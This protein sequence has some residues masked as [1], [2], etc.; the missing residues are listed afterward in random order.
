MLRAL[1]R[2]RRSSGPSSGR[3]RIQEVLRRF[4]VR[5]GWRR[6]SRDGPAH[7]EVAERPVLMEARVVWALIIVCH[8]RHSFVWPPALVSME[9]APSSVT[10]RQLPPPG[11]DPLQTH[12]TS[13]VSG[14]H[15]QADGHPLPGEASAGDLLERH[16]LGQSHTGGTE[17]IAS[18]SRETPGENRCDRGGRSTGRWRSLLIAAHQR[19][20]DKLRQGTS[21][22]NSEQ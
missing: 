11:V 15:A 7:P 17:V 2:P 19:L 20:F 18:G 14:V 3:P 4:I 6:Q 8:S 1:Y 10:W 21:S 16:A 5:R 9:A 12:A 13:T 22:S